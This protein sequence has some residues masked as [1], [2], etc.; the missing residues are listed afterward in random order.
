MPEVELIWKHPTAGVVSSSP[1]IAEGVLYVG[2]EDGNLFALDAETGEPRWMHPT[3]DKVYSSPSV[4]DGI[5][6]VGSSDGRLY[7]LRASA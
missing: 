1:V 4:T 3:G 6:Y 2:S 5:L 7:A